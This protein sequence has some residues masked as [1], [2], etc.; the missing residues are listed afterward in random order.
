M[1]SRWI[2]QCAELCTIICKVSPCMPFWSLV[3]TIFHD[4]FLKYFL[5]R[6]YTVQ[7]D[8]TLS[9]RSTVN[10][11]VQLVLSTVDTSECLEVCLYNIM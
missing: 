10:F 9:F 1:C 2:K 4:F 6:A 7:S 8:I 3:I 5:S 11:V